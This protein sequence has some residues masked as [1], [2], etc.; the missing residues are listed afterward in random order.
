MIVILNLNMASYTTKIHKLVRVL[1]DI[2]YLMVK[3]VKHIQIWC[4]HLSG[5]KSVVKLKMSKIT[6]EIDQ[7]GTVAILNFKIVINMCVSVIFV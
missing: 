3:S 5:S 1:A 2:I 7:N 4:K 6:M